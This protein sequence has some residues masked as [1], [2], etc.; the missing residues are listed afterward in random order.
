MVVAARRLAAAKKSGALPEGVD[1]DPGDPYAV[2]DFYAHAFIEDARLLGMKIV[3]DAEAQLRNISANVDF[4][5]VYACEASGG[6]KMEI[7]E[8]ERVKVV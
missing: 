7:S 8:E 4:L 6:H 1:I 5:L 3:F 2:A